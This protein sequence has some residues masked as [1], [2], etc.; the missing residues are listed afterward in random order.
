LRFITRDCVPLT[1]ISPNDIGDVEL[2][3][4]YK[5]NGPYRT[6][7]SETEYTCTP[8]I[9]NFAVPASHL[10]VNIVSTPFQAAFHVIASDSVVVI[11]SEV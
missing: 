2:S 7:A 6:E 10:I 3:Q 5:L 1:L 11:P 4:R 8:S 9:K